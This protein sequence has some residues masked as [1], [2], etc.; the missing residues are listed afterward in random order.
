MLCPVGHGAAIHQH[1]VEFNGG[2]NKVMHAEGQQQLQQE[3]VDPQ[4]KIARGNQE[5]LHHADTVLDH[6]PDNYEGTG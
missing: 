5:L 6:G 3:T 4:T 1:A 2:I